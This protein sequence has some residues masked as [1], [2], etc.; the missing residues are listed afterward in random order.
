MY[1]VTSWMGAIAAP[2]RP[3]RPAASTTALRA[4]TRGRMP[5]ISAASRFCAMARMA[6]PN[7]VWRS[8]R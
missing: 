1:G 4:T 5:T 6:R 7:W 2:A 3:H 8:T